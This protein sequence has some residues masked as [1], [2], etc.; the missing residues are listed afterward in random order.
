VCLPSV[1]TD[2]WVKKGCHIHVD[3]VELTVAPDHEGGVI[4]RPYFSTT[5]VAR[6]TRAIRIA[7]DDCLSDPAM[8]KLW[9]RAIKN[10]SR[11]MLGY[12]GAHKSW[13]NGRMLE[14][15]FLVLALERYEA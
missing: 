13:A 9:T 14:F 12:E 11:Y 15:K 6:A 5:S 7:R 3:G 4:F 10:A 1:V 8:R 2:D